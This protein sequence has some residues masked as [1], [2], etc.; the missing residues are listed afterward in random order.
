MQWLRR[1]CGEVKAS[2]VNPGVEAGNAGDEVGYPRGWTGDE[3]YKCFV[4]LVTTRG[5]GVPREAG[6]S[7]ESPKSPGIAVIGEPHE[8]GLRISER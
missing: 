4:F 7:P 8:N 2:P 3:S 6:Q 1:I 5:E